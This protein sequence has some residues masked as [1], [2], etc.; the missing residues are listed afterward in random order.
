MAKGKKSPIYG[1]GIND[2][3]EPISWVIIDSE[4]KSKLKICPI[5]TD[6]QSM[7]QRGFSP[8]LKSKRPTYEGVTVCEE[9]KYFSV[10]RKWVL[11]EQPNKDWINC[12]PDKDLLSGSSKI[13]SP[14]T[15]VYISGKIN[16]FIIDRGN[17]RGKYMIGVGERRPNGKYRSYCSNPF[18]GKT[19]EHLG[20]FTTELEAHLAWQSKKHEYA[21]I[22]AEQQDDPRV[23][24]A[25]RK[26]YAPDT[27]WTKR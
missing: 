26:R 3:H 15:V 5:Y 1:W 21:C 24:D 27:D 2:W 8:L 22:F 11:E 18:T 14:N 25:L 10:Y 7:L 19:R 4:G 20:Y 12:V 17:D 23:A 16:C 9:W 6:W 13:Y